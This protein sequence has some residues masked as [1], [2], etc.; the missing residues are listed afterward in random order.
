VNVTVGGSPV[1][2]GFNWVM[3]SGENWAISGP[4]G[5]GKTTI[6]K[7]ISGENLQAYANEIYLFGHRKGHGQSIW[8]I[9]KRIGYISAELQNRQP[10]SQTAL[11]I[12]CSG[13]FGTMGLY[14]RCREEE[15]HLAAKWM[16]ILG[17]AGLAD[18]YFGRLS[19]GQ[20]QLVLIARAMVQAPLLLILDEPCDGLDTAN[21]KKILDVLNLIGCHSRTDLL[22]VPSHEE[23]MLHCITHILE[24]DAGS[25]KARVSR[26]F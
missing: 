21:R 18:T 22:Y 17:I 15:V 19:H 11:D 24:V 16:A 23:E 14:K 12:V 4:A 25:A 9:K 20:K 5:A 1:L 2:R 6:L 13:Y 26:S 7:L 3:R 10:L 8:D